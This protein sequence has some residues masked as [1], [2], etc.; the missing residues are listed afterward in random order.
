MEINA[1]L[2]NSALRRRLFDFFKSF[3]WGG[4]I[5]NKLKNFQKQMLKL[6]VTSEQQHGKDFLASLKGRLGGVG[7][8]TH[9][10]AVLLRGIK[11]S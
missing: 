8:G 1:D 11:N 3:M 10:K 5:K 4:E 6:S 2:I 9:S 7:G